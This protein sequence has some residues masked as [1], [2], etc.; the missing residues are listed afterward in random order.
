[1][2]RCLWKESGTI[3]AIQQ[4]NQYFILKKSLLVDFSW[5]HCPSCFLC[6][7]IASR[8]VIASQVAAPR[9]AFLKRSEPLS[10]RRLEQ[11]LRQPGLWRLEKESV[12]HVATS[13]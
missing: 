10:L 9:D 6:R 12:C 1:M 13:S 7:S 4:T 5:P 3:E 8:V 11:V 2:F